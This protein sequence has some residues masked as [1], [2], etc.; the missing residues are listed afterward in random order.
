MGDLNTVGL[1]DAPAPSKLT[2]GHRGYRGQDPILTIERIRTLDD[3]ERHY[4]CR[5]KRPDIDAR[6]EVEISI[7]RRY[8]PVTLFICW[9]ELKKLKHEIKEQNLRKAV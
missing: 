3:S 4:C 5:S 1:A 7:E 9:E 2:M 8:E 6:F